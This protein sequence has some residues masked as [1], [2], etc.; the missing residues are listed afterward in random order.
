MTTDD[1]IPRRRQRLWRVIVLL[2]VI[3]VVTVL[4]AIAVGEPFWGSF[5]A[6]AVVVVGFGAVIIQNEYGGR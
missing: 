6:I 4:R 3:S 2:T 5:I 1:E